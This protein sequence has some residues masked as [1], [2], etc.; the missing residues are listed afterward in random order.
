MPMF[1]TT[2]LAQVIRFYGHAMQ[3]MMGSVLEKNLQSFVDLQSRLAEQSKGLYDPKSFT[4][5]AWAQLMTGQ[6]PL[7]Q[8]LM[9]SYLEQSKN[10]FAQMQEQMSK[11]AGSLFPMPGL[12]P[13]NKP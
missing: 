2:M 13:T 10:L 4:P 11:Q 7:V 5:E 6:A 1:S 9:G 12:T 8:N 3:G